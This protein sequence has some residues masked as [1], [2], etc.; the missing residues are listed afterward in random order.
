MSRL[1]LATR[2]W[3][4]GNRPKTSEVG[5]VSRPTGSLIAAIGKQNTILLLQSG[6]GRGQEE[7]EGGTR[8]PRMRSGDRDT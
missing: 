8:R 7:K 5:G 6:E 3:R 2:N 4:A 1:P